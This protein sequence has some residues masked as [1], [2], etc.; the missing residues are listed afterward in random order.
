MK[1]SKV[2]LRVYGIIF[3]L[4]MV[5][6]RQLKAQNLSKEDKITYLKHYDKD[7]LL[8]IALPLGGIG[9]GTVSLG[10]RGELRDWEIMNV[11]A[12]GYST[13]TDGNDAPFFAIHIEEGKDKYTKALLGP[14]YD[15]EYEHYEGRSV[16]H[17][18]LPRFK[19]TSFDASYPFG[20]VNLSDP[21]LPVIV[22]LTG[23]NP[24]I[25][26]DADA[27]GIPIAILNYE[28]ENITSKPIIVSVSGNIRNFIGKDGSEF[29]TDWKGDYIPIGANKNQNKFKKSKEVSGIYM[30]SNKVSK[31]S[32]AYGTIAL[33]T[34]NKTGKISYRTSSTTLSWSNSVLDFW[35]DFSDDGMLTEKS[36]LVNN[37]PMASLSVQKMIPPGEKKSFIFYLTWHF[38]NRFAW[39]KTKVGNYYCTKYS[40]AWDVIEKEVSNLSLLKNKTVEF[41]NSI[42]NSSFDKSV[43]EA[44]LFN[45][46]TLRSQTVFRTLDG[47][48]FGWEGVMDRFGSCKGSCTHVWNYEQ[49]TA[50]LFGDL[51]KSMR[52]VEFDYAT[53]D[54]G[55]MSFRVELPLDKSKAGGAT[56]ADG[57]MGTIMKFY[58]EWQLSGD[59]EFLKK[60]W[61]KVKA[62]LSYAW[63]KNGW[64]RDRDGV[65][66]GI[67]HNTMDVNYIGPN[68]QMQIWYL[69]ALKAGSLM[70]TAV[71]DMDFSK[72]CLSL[73]NK[74]NIWTDKNLFNGEYYEQIVMSK[75]FL[76]EISSGESP[77]FIEVDQK[78]PKYPDYQ[79]AKGCLV[80]QLVGQYMAHVIGLG[81]LVDKNNVKTA[82]QSILKY[83]QMDNMSN[84]FNNMRS[85]AMGDE[86][87]LLMASFPK[88]RPK[89]PFPYFSEV[90]TGFEYTAAIGM[91]YE[92]M[93]K[94][95][96][97]VINNIRDRYNGSKRS[98]FDEAECGH[99]Y[100]RAMASWAAILA[101]SGFHYSGVDKYIAFTSKS[102]KYFWSNGYAWGVCEI[103]NKSKVANMKFTVLFGTIELKEFRLKDFGI[104]KFNKP[105]IINE[106]ETVLI[107]IQ[108]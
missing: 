50:F 91:L 45:L 97:Q 49:A 14:L 79:L 56:A 27:S 16:N 87:A 76:K 18:G 46:S 61:E 11:P 33:T 72:T 68:P 31:K 102:G 69:G 57:Q 65:M 83:N 80:D 42:V 58:R 48:M 10:G 92:G 35:D 4:S 51:A 106:N 19:N 93:E 5:G 98:P 81:Y 88:G 53:N 7:H 9:T 99:H 24:L 2:A 96:L 52:E 29:K 78:D 40:N 90:M 74:G 85:Y 54:E 6:I 94:E 64:D 70:A 8:R 36:N 71:G 95:G 44:A 47:R 26:G 30:F 82:L 84:H 104:H 67:Q 60:H 107:K 13:V 12:K 37:D 43:K 59:H 41:V 23:F 20:K 86:S 66:E 28:V 100:A 101:Q 21:S 77:G 22:K 15:S 105:R 73:Y 25:P 38:P 39:S 63:I 55:R 1:F 62:V 75:D 103:E 108:P 3:F 32:P 34:P 17:H 89:V